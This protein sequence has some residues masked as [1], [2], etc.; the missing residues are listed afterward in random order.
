[1]E[2]SHCKLCTRLTDGLSCYNTYCLTYLD[3]LS[4]RHV[5]AIALRADTYMTAAGKY[6]TN[7]NFSSNSSLHYSLSLHYPCCTFW[8]N[9]MVCLNYNFTIVIIYSLTGISSLY[10]LF[11]AFYLFLAIHKSR[12]PHTRNFILSCLTI[13]FSYNKILRYIYKSSC[14]VS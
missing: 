3:R 10:S 14:K 4:C 1:M 7:L 6:C 5:C 13:S 8:S 2:G 11:K 12:N 9:D